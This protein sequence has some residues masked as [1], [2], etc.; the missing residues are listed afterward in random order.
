MSM[1]PALQTAVVA[2]LLADATVAALV[3]A[4]RHGKAVFAP[5]QDFDRE[6]WPR[7]TIETPQRI[8]GAIQCSPERSECF[9]TLH[10]W[11]RGPQASLTAG[12]VAD[13]AITALSTPLTVQGFLVTG[14]THQSSRPVGDPDASVAH[15]VSVFRFILQPTG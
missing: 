12:A 6:A 5:H 13:A 8:G 10:A 15:V 3:A 11:A 7:L 14:Q 2:A 9:V 4:T 1:R